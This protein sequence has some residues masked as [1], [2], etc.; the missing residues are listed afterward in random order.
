MPNPHS[1]VGAR[2]ILTRTHT[3]LLPSPQISTDFVR[4][5]NDTLSSGQEVRVRV[6]N[7]DQERGKF[8]VTMIPEG[9]A[10]APRAADA[11]AEASGDRPQLKQQ[12]RAAKAARKAPRAAVPVS[13]GDVIKGKIA[14]VAP[15][16]VFVEVGEGFTGLLHETEMVRGEGVPAPAEGQE[17]EVT[18]VS[19]KGD[20]IQLSQ[21]SAEELQQVGRGCSRRGC[22][23]L[24][25]GWQQQLRGPAEQSGGHPGLA[26]RVQGDARASRLLC[27]KPWA[28]EGQDS[29]CFFPWNAPAG[30]APA[31]FPSSAFR[32]HV[33]VAHPSFPALLPLDRP[34]RRSCVCLA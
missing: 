11:E 28:Q 6:M 33:L 29:L 25:A 10:P 9:A 4:N 24:L 3:P 30:V 17:I 31:C 23:R 18:V 21:R 14:T 7:I 32:L 1:S 19:V 15:F 22:A 5:V 16:G 12:A 8:A 2:A 34:R 27:S 13:A 26:G 20:K